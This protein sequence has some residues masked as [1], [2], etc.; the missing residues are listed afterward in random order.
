MA[1][2]NS[3][4]ARPAELTSHTRQHGGAKTS[5]FGEIQFHADA[6]GIV[7]KELR[8]AGPRYDAL[9][10]FDA[11]RLQ[12]LAHTVD[13]GGCESD[14]IEPSGVLVFLLGAAHHDALAR[15][16]RPHQMHGRRAARIEPVAGEVERRTVAVLEA[17]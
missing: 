16:A 1:E 6:I 7:E 15:L 5:R 4:G 14:V 17:K 3:A 9:A 10:E 13:V 8:I 12:A 2:T 11:L